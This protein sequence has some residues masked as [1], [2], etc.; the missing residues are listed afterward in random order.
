[1][2]GL[3][4]RKVFGGGFPGDQAGG[5][6]EGSLHPLLVLVEQH[7][8]RKTRNCNEA[9]K[10][11]EGGGEMRGRLQALALGKGSS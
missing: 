8:A 11:K 7:W 6:G 2:A 10:T 4:L 3:L 5:G 9:R 1:L